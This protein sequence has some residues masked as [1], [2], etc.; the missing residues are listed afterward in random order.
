[1]PR[2]ISRGRAAFAFSPTETDRCLCSSRFCVGP[3]EGGVGLGSVSRPPYWSR[4]CSSI[5]NHLVAFV[6]V[7][8]SPWH[9]RETGLL[10]AE[11]G[12][13]GMGRAAP[14]ATAR[15]LARASPRSASASLC[16]PRSLSHHRSASLSIRC[17]SSTYRL[18][19][20]GISAFVHACQPCPLNLSNL[21]TLPKSIPLPDD[22]PRRRRYT[23]PKMHARCPGVGVTGCRRR[24]CRTGSA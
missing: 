9:P 12:Q 4:S 24:R 16:D 3:D 22:S 21:I 8:E 6:D 2:H 1:M 7:A 18:I 11:P 13:H 17:P 15:P 5:D 10:R 19:P 23:Q 14:P 20:V